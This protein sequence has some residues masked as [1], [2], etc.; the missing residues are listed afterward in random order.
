[1]LI[2]LLDVL[3]L[4]VSVRT[5]QFLQCN[6]L[7]AHIFDLLYKNPTLTSYG[8]MMERTDY[9][10]YDRSLTRFQFD[11]DMYSGYNI[12][13]VALTETSDER[14]KTTLMSSILIVARL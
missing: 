14:G 2:I 9:M 6:T 12:T 1:M 13:C 10:F 5:D 8:G 11:V 3:N 4:I 7:R